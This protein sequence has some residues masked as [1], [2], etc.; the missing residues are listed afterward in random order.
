VE[1]AEEEPE[2][3]LLK[4]LGCWIE[5]AQGFLDHGYLRRSV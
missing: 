2:A 1:G 4:L 3:L 5:V